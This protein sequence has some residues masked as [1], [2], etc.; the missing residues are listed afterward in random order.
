MFIVGETV[1][2]ERIRTAHFCCDT[3]ACRGACCTLE[4]GRGAPLED[5]EV[6]EILS[7]LPLI[8]NEMTEA[9]R[10]VVEEE[11][12][13][14]GGPGD[15][16]TPCV[17]HRECAYVYFEGG[18]ARCLFERAFLEGRIGW[19][20]PISCHLFPLRVRTFGS[21]AMRYEEID[22]CAEGRARGARES[23]PLHEFLREPLIRRFG[24]AW[25]STF[26]GECAGRE[27]LHQLPPATPDQ[28]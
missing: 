9:G 18:I 13:I 24:I 16:A 1:I 4:G 10:N 28:H 27:G 22:E 15:Y 7:A 6:E 2:E 26:V 25:Y 12:P 23:I 20:K 14:D 5:R 19:R 21:T 3:A 17:G 11:G 8:R